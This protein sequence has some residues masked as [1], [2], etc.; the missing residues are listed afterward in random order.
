MLVAIVGLF[1]LGGVMGALGYLS[2]GFPALLVPVALLL[3][4]SLPSIIG[5]RDS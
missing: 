5:R 4:L 3:A 1:F 2:M